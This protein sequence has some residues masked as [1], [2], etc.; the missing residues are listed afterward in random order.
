MGQNK[1]T[2]HKGGGVFFYIKE[3][4]T[5]SDVGLVDEMLQD[6]DRIRQELIDAGII[7]EF[8]L[9]NKDPNIK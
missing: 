9:K 4:G 8:V 6:E 1:R 2:M 3:D 7:K 5:P